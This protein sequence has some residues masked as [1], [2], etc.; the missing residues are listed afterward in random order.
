[1]A[2]DARIPLSVTP[3]EWNP[4]SFVEQWD[5]SRASEASTAAQTQTNQLQKVAFGDAMIQRAARNGANSPEVWDQEFKRLADAGVPGAGE[6]VGKWHP[7]TV[8]EVMRRGQPTAAGALQQAGN[9]AAAQQQPGGDS[10]LSAMSIEQKKRGIE[11]I[12]K[13]LE[14][15]KTAPRNKQEY[16][17]DIDDVVAAGWPEASHW[18]NFIPGGALGD[19]TFGNQF[20]GVLNNLTAKFQELQAGLSQGGL[21]APREPQPEYKTMPSEAGPLNV[22]IPPG[23]GKPSIEFAPVGGTANPAFEKKFAPGAGGVGVEPTLSPLSLSSM[24][25]QYLAGDKSVFQNLGRGAQGAANVVA[26]RDEVYATAKERGM[27]GS[28]VASAMAEF[29]GYTAGQRAIGTRGANVSMAGEEARSMGN[30]VIS[31]SRAVDRS[32]FPDWN[33]VTNSFEARTGGTEVKDFAAALN[34]YINVYSRAIAPS[35]QGPT[36]SDKEHARELLQTA[37]SH[38]QVESVMRILNTE[39]D[40]ALAAPDTVKRKYRE[41]FTGKKSAEPAVSDDTPDWDK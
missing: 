36:V 18:K 9:T 16:D 21:D 20:S 39:I 13:L 31:T 11:G 37:F 32:S 12:G 35:G 4:L 7:S 33:A 40:L 17:A 30:L 22:S 27:T 1:M 23:G 14:A 10:Q 24:A 19:A 3:P 28:E 5:R 2:I 41:K 25:D 8:Q 34:S 38:G 26:L 29:A 15:F 6:M